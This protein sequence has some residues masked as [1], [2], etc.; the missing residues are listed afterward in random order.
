VSAQAGRS[1]AGLIEAALSTSTDPFDL[2]KTYTA[3][4]AITANAINTRT[5]LPGEFILWSTSYLVWYPTIAET[6]IYTYSGGGGTASGIFYGHSDV[7]ED[8]LNYRPVIAQLALNA[9]SGG[10]AVRA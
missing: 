6:P 9:G 8:G 4:W 5:F 7:P 3:N 2:T 1:I 10:F